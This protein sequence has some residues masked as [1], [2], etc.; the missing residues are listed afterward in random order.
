MTKILYHIFI[1]KNGLYY[2]E[3]YEKSAV[4]QKKGEKT[5]T[6]RKRLKIDFG[7]PMKEQYSDFIKRFLA[8]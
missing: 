4:N 1:K 3:E 2:F 5:I 8:D 6:I 7:I